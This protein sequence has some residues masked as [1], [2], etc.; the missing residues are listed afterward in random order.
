VSFTF[1]GG[2]FAAGE[3]VSVWL[4]RPGGQVDTVDQSQVQRSGSGVRVVFRPAQ[5]EGDWAITAQGVSTGRAVVGRFK[6]TR[7]Y[8]A[9]PGTPRPRNVNGSV[10]PAEAGQRGQF[11]LQAQGF[12][13]NESLEFWITSPDG[14]YVLQQNVQ[15]DRNGRIGV[16]PALAVAFGAQNPAGVYGYHYRGVTS[17]VR[18]DIYFTFSGQP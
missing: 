6:V 18:A 4:T 5:V 10:T 14:L 11:R 7:D 1:S 3:R 15:A 2:D 9:P 17:R 16:N 13:A 8:I 12:R